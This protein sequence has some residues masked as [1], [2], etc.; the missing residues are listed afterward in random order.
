MGFVINLTIVGIL[1]VFLALVFL[2]AILTIFGKVFSINKNAVKNDPVTARNGASVPEVNEDKKLDAPDGDPSNDEL[3]AV[4]TAAVLSSL[5]RPP[6]CK[7]RVKS[8]RRIPQT[9]PIWNLRGRSEYLSG[10]L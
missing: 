10:K 7:I 1:V 9:S 5:R 3:V 2:A 6:E 4:L 8:F